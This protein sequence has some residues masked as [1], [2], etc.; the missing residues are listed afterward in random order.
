MECALKI[1]FLSFGNSDLQKSAKRIEK[2]ALKMDIYD[3]ISIYNEHKLDTD[4]RKHFS[5]K[6]RKHTRG[7]GYWCWKPQIIL[8]ALSKMKDGDI[9]HY[10]DMGCHLNANGVSRL[11][12]YINYASKSQSGILAFQAIPPDFHDGQQL[13]DLRDKLWV[14]GDLLDYFH[15]RDRKEIVETP[16]YGATTLFIKKSIHSINFIKEWVTVYYQDFT[17]TDD[18]PSK[19]PNLEGFIENRH[20]QSIFSILCKLYKVTT[21]SAYEYWYPQKE[22]TARP[23][24]ETLKNYP[25]HARRDKQFGLRYMIEYYF[26]AVRRRFLKRLG[27]GLKP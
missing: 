20:D 10:A 16:T 4:F 25:I 26:L 19:S 13:P 9:L 2:Q 11:K 24:W 5:Q 23:D 21:L 12:D 15:V 18:T 17:L 8:Q 3:E 6:L 27:V 7:F 22:N 14:K 1:I